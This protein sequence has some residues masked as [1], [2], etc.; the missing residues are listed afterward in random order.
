[1]KRHAADEPPD[2]ALL[3]QIFDRP[4]GRGADAGA[5]D[6]VELDPP[7]GQRVSGEIFRAL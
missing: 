7:F 3:A 2:G 5:D 1:V 6:R 4:A